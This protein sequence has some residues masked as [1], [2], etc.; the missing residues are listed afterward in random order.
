MCCIT[1]NKQHTFVVILG[2]F[3]ILIFYF[4]TW[5]TEKNKALQ[6]LYRQTKNRE[7]NG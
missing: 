4:K 1:G 5:L 2:Q 7:R 6:F 3:Y